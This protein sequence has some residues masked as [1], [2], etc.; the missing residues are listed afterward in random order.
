M[1][2]DELLDH[3]R[4]LAQDKLSLVEE[5]KQYA[6]SESEVRK[7]DDVIA[8]FRGGSYRWV[9]SMPSDNGRICGWLAPVLSAIVIG[10]W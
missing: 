5:I 2:D 1:D 10:P 9:C 4:R 3:V 7:D 6:N 8:S